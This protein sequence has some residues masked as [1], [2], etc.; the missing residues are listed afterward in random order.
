MG[1]GES[2]HTS[3]GPPPRPRPHPLGGYV[4]EVAAADH[5]AAVEAERDRLRSALEA[6][7]D[8]LDCAGHTPVSVPA[9]G[10]VPE[11]F[12]FDGQCF[13]AWPADPDEWCASCIAHIALGGRP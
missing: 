13:E 4:I 1:W 5:L 7:D 8:L 6:I 11:R 12:S 2:L 9:G 10:G 3:A